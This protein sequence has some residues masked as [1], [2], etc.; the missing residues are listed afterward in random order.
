VTQCPLLVVTQCLDNVISD[1]AGGNLCQAGEE[2]QK[3]SSVPCTFGNLLLFTHN[4]LIAHR[5]L[6][7]VL[8]DQHHLRDVSDVSRTLVRQRGRDDGRRL[9]GLR[10]VDGQSRRLHALQ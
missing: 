1:D 10:V 5:V 2:G 9:V 6:D 7:S 8:R 4:D 3:T